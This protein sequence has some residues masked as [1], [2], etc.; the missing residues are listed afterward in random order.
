VLIPPPL[1]TDSIIRVVAPSGPFD[2]ALF[3]R[4]VGWLA[5]SCQV[6]FD[7]LIFERNGFLAGS[8]ERRRA[9]FQS[10]IDDPAAAAIVCARGGWG[11]ARF[12]QS[13]DYS[14]LL[15]FPKWLVGFS[16]PTTIHMNAWRL[17]VATMHANNLVALGRND[18]IARETWLEALRCPMKHRVLRGVA[19][20]AGK[21]SGA[22]VGG[23][24]T[25]LTCGLSTGTLSLPDG[26]I[27]ALEDV[28]ESSYR[29]DR[30]LNALVS[31]GALDRIGAVAL[32]EFFECDSGT[33]QVN[34][35]EVLINHLLPMGIPVV[36]DLP[37]GHG[38]INVPLPLGPLATLDGTR[39][40]LHVGT[41]A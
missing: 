1:R 38:R 4:A 8:D 16:D 35:A 34:V 18:T 13:L 28:T 7:P 27:L 6:R 15:R 41:A 5:Q 25:M 21:V 31:S 32:G 12:S 3:W 23:N 37:F 11:A 19:A 10:A 24:L 14:Q 22:L 17:G 20:V 29:V 40:E 36:T 30:M 26:C 9:E 2:R 33:H 39:G